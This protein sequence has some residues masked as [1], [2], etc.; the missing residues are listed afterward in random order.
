M[1]WT[2]AASQSGHDV[3]PDAS[4]RGGMSKFAS[5]IKN[6]ISFSLKKTS[7]EYQRCI[8]FLH[9]GLIEVQ[10]FR[11][12]KKLCKCKKKKTVEMGNLSK[13][14]DSQITIVYRKSQHGKLPMV[15]LTFVKK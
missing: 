8:F 1:A 11:K 14:H 10:N 2:P 12:T 5:I 9:S 15:I 13:K 7:G 4:L 3:M 6:L